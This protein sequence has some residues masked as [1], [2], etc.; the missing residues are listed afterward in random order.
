M[1]RLLPD[2]QHLYKIVCDTAKH[3][4]ASQMT[5]KGEGEAKWS[6]Q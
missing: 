3:G 4:R 5:D 6:Q 1:E 2:C